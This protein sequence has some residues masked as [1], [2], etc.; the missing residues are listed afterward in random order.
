ME[1]PR[2]KLFPSYEGLA[3]IVEELKPS[4]IIVDDDGTI[5]VYFKDLDKE[6]VHIVPVAD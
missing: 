4:M 5:N 2:D 3:L 6:S 1:I